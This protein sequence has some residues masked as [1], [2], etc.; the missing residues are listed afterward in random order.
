MAE[1]FNHKENHKKTWN[2]MEWN[3]LFVFCVCTRY[4]VILVYC[5]ILTG[6]YDGVARVWNTS[7]DLLL[8]TVQC[9]GHSG[10]PVKC[11]TWISDGV[12]YHF[13]VICGICY[14]C[15][16]ISVVFMLIDLQHIF[17]GGYM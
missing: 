1:L 12:W 17:V 6:S 15:L 4:S 8:D 9:A 16:C 10:Q 14:Q 2:G 5:R 3:T 11:V 7:G 13:V